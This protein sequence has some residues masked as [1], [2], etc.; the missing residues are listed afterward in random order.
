MLS[1]KMEK[2]L[3]NLTS[4]YIPFTLLSQARIS[5][6]VNVVR[7]IEMREGE[8]FQITGGKGK[9]YLFVIEGALN[10]ITHGEVRHVKGP[11]E[12]RNH[13]SSC[14]QN[15]LPVRWWPEATPLFAMRIVTCLMT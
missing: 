11:E 6:V 13:R 3:E 1:V 7:F 8:I 12:T 14:S 10:V 15:R 9:D 5:E 2:V 4:H